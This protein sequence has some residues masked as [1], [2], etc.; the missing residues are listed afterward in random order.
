MLNILIPSIPERKEILDILLNKL[1][2][3][4]EYCKNIHSTLG[5]VS[6]IV[7]NSKKYLNGGLSIGKKRDFLLKKA[8][9]KYVC[10]LDDD[11]NISPNYVETLLFLCNE[12]KDV[13]TFKSLFQCDTYW[14]IIDMSLF[15]ENEEA[16]NN[17]EIKRS[18]WHICPIKREIAIKYSF[19]DIS[20]GEDWLWISK[21]LQDLKTEA[22]TD[23]LIHNYNH[24][25]NISEADKIVNKDDKS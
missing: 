12:D 7:D 3:Q 5:T 22:K 20:Y 24:H 9:E 11:D 10:F 25:E 19:D 8:E 23:A 1:T 18:V 21:M 16:S 14:A 4:I 13:C 6:I 15:N 17:R 2:S